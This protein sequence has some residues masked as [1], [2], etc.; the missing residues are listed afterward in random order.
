MMKYLYFAAA[1]VLAASL[2]ANCWLIRRNAKMQDEFD[3][4]ISEILQSTREAD[5]DAIHHFD[6]D[7][8]KAEILAE[9]KR[10][11]L[12]NTDTDSISVSDLLRRCRDGLFKTSSTDRSS[13]TSSSAHG[14]LRPSSDT[15]RPE[16]R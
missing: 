11:A 16:S 4:H 7:K 14:S 12:K 9:E 8:S 10:N 3:A 5:R 13:D 15:N 6:I 1:L 2:T